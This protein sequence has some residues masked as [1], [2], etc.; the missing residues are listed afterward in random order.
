MKRIIPFLLLAFVAV[1]CE[2]D[3][4]TVPIDELQLG[5][6]CDERPDHPKCTGGDE[7]PKLE[8][9]FVFPET[10]EAAQA[11]GGDCRWPHWEKGY[12]DN[13]EEHPENPYG[14]TWRCLVGGN[15]ILAFQVED[16]DGN[17]VDGTVK[18]FRC[19]DEAGVPQ[20]WHGCGVRSRGKPKYHA[21]EYALEDVVGGIVGV[22]LY[23]S[24]RVVWHNYPIQGQVDGWGGMKWKYKAVD[25]RKAD[26]GSAWYNIMPPYGY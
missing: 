9:R 8:Y 2:K 21:E 26:L 22:T 3:G 10:W 20:L 13:P 14:R 16:L 6:D 11:L 25:S 15:P 24:D 18:F 19:E 4:P 23:E 12:E 1:A 7:D 5:V 17:P